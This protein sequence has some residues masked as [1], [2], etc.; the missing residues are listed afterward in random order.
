[1]GRHHI[2]FQIE[3]MISNRFFIGI[4]TSSQTDPSS[5]FSP[6]S[7]VNGWWPCLHAVVCGVSEKSSTVKEMKKGDELTLILDCDNKQIYIIHDRTK[8]ILQ[9]AVDIQKCPFP[10][11]LVVGLV[12]VGNGIRIIR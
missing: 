9:L 11:K 1:M 4:V 12:D 5:V 8:Q 7:T 2:R 6:F 3:K 10:W